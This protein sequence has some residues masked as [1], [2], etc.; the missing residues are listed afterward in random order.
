MRLIRWTATAAALTVGCIAL[1]ACSP[2]TALP[3]GDKAADDRTGTLQVWLYNEAGNAPKEAV[4]AKAV[5]EFQASHQGVTVNVS[6][7]DTDAA[8][9]AAKMKGAFNDPSS[10]PDLVEFGNTDLPGYVAAGGLAEIGAELDGWSSKGD[11]D[12]AIA[13]TAVLDGKTYGLPWWVGV[14]ALYYR[15]D[16]FTE[17]G[18]AAPASYDELVAA[19]KAVHAQHP[20]TF[21]IAVGGKYTFGALPFVWDAGGDIATKSG[22]KYTAAIASAE[23]QA[24]VKRYTDLFGADGCPAQQCADLTGGKTVDLFAAGKA[25]MAILPNSS[26]SKV[27]AGPA[28]GKYAVVPLPGSKAGS[29]A[30]AFAGGNNLGVMKAAKHRTLAVEFAE[31]LAGP[32][33]QQAMYDAMGNLP[34]LKSV[35]TAVAAK[36]AFLKPFT[37][38]IAAGTRFVPMDQ[39][40]AQIDAQAVVPTLLQQVVTGKADVAKA[41]GDAAQQINTAFA[42]H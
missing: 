30:P 39:G 17:A 20:D 33:N 23:S 34:T 1:S 42:A 14:R 27:D 36:D 15:T 25:A 31:L 41:S 11:L 21:G 35:N 22:D 28:K 40:W 29:I 18:L 8:A 10:A 16:L 38:T 19:T 4:V 5:T 13:K 12:P 7:I 6:Y 2:G 24:G 32:A 26:R 9:R 3:A 37:D